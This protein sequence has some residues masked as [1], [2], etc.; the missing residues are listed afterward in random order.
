[1][2][3][4]TVTGADTALVEQSVRQLTQHGAVSCCGSNVKIDLGDSAF[5]AS[6]L[7]DLESIPG[8]TCVQVEEGEDANYCRMGDD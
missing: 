1:M 8:V 4:Q 7:R 3:I 6:F 5:S 2:L